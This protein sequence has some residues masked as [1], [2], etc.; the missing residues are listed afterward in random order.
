MFCGRCL[1]FVLQVPEDGSI[2]GDRAALIDSATALVHLT[3]LASPRNAFELIEES[4]VEKLLTLLAQ[5]VGLG[6]VTSRTESKHVQLSI[7]GNVLHTLSGLATLPEARARYKAVHS[8]PLNLVLCSSFT[9]SPK[10]MQHALVVR[11]LPVV[12]VLLPS[13]LATTCVGSCFLGFVISTSAVLDVFVC[14]A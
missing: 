14:Q 2:S 3:C 10:V 7:L 13:Q 9:Q 11:A 1:V 8:F 5:L 4:G 12:V 6:G